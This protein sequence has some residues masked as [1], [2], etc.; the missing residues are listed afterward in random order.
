MEPPPP[1][2]LIVS[3]R[4]TRDAVPRLCAD[5]EALL[6]TSPDPTTVYCDLSGVVHPDLTTVEAIARLSLTARRTGARRLRLC[7]TPPELRVL[8][9]LVGLEVPLTQGDG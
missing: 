8:L 1:A 6:R 5:L 2:A 7:G 4:L 3:G 9:E